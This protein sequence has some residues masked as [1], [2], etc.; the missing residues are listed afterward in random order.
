MKLILIIAGEEYLQNIT[1]ILIK[2]GYHAT[3][4]ASNGEFL[5]YGDAVLLLGVEDAEADQVIKIM[6]SEG[7]YNPGSE[8]PFQNQV[9]IFV[10]PMHLFKKVHTIKKYKK[11]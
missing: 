2:H 6:E 1:S 3:E 11:I 7:G 4:I 10:I 9:N 8:R 5:Q